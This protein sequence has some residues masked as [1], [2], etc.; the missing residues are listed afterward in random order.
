MLQ[1]LSSARRSMVIWYRNRDPYPE[2]K[3][4]LAVRDHREMVGGLWDEI[5]RLQFE[6]LRGRG[7]QPSDVLLDVGCG[8]FRAGRFF[9]EYLEPGHYLGIDKQQALVAEGRK[10]E[11]PASLWREKKPQIVISSSFEFRRFNQRPDVALA[12]SVFTHLRAADI[13][14]CLRRLRRH[15]G[16][17]PCTLYATFFESPF[18]VWHLLH[19]HSS[20][21]FEYTRAE[22]ARFGREAGWK[23]EYLGDWGHPKRQMMMAF[24]AGR[25]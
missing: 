11:V 1:L 13:R 15:V 10:K 4:G 24:H 7:L 5:G 9:I 14:R 20:R 12:Q 19:S 2:G 21:R 25:D 3:E 17:K 23:T 16:D 6:W 22:L 18:P 8:S